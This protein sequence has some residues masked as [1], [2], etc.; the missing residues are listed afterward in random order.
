ME[1][2][3]VTVEQA[4]ELT[5]AVEEHTGEYPL[6]QGFHGSATPGPNMSLSYIGDNLAAVGFELIVML[7]GRTAHQAC[8]AGYTYTAS[9]F[10]DEMRQ[11]VLK[12]RAPVTEAVGHQLIYYWPTVRL[13]DQD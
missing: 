9:D 10:V 1:P 12:V 13:L 7:A 5:A 2:I 8:R 11:I 3:A 4:M 6:I